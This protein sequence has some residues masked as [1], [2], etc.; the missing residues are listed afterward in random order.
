MRFHGYYD[1][2]GHPIE[3]DE[4]RR[5]ACKPGYR[6]IGRE[7]LDFGTNPL[8]AVTW[9]IITWWTGRPALI[10]LP[11]YM[12]GAPPLIFRTVVYPPAETAG[13]CQRK[14][15]AYR[16]H[17]ASEAEAVGGHMEFKAMLKARAI[18]DGG[19]A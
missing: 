7:W 3:E 19:P 16:R 1:R 9:Q 12:A 11:G 6:L 10:G 8:E 15:G 17:Y 18:G 4:W 2:Q 13:F 14:Y 5:L